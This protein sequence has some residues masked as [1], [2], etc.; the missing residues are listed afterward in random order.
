MTAW[1]LGL[2]AADDDVHL[3]E[4]AVTDRILVAHNADDFILLHKAWRRWLAGWH[5]ALRQEQV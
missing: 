5:R 2:T 3:W 4:A 1:D